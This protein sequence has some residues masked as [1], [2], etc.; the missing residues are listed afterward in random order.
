MSVASSAERA[1][2][3]LRFSRRQRYAAL[4]LSLYLGSASSFL[5]RQVYAQASESDRATA[6]ALAEEGNRALTNKDYALAEDRFRRA[7]ALVHAPSLVVDHARSLVGLGRF[8]E[9]YLDYDQT[10]KEQVA[11]TS[12]AA[13]KRAVKDAEREI[14][15]VE[16]KFGW[17]TLTVTGGA[18]RPIV[19]VGDRTIPPERLGAAFPV[20]A[21]KPVLRVA[22]DGFV[23]KE[24]PLSIGPGERVELSVQLEPVPVAVAPPPP[25]TVAPQRPVEH[26][27][28][29]RPRQPK[30]QG[31]G[32]PTYVAFGVGALG[33]SVGAVTGVLFLSERSKLKSACPSDNDCPPTT[34]DDRSRY[35][36]YS[37]VS[38]ISVLVGLAGAGTGVALLL[39]KTKTSDSARN[40]AQLQPYVSVGSVG[41]QGSF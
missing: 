36:L 14:K 27:A 39:S 15:N 21:G 17:L 26:P 7:E 25:P 38:G 18:D 40:K 2:S 23:T 22:A 12:P 10:R 34:R 30:E 9:A 11:P 4:L 5:T 6:R 41:V 3:R 33:L 37:Y 16:G 32:T 28:R 19:N 13:W 24:V 20:D 8:A 1:G 29:Q 35:Y 31:P